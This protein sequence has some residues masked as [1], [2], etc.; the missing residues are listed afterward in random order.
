V[1]T[2][3]ALTAVAAPAALAQVAAPPTRSVTV[4]V[5]GSF[6]LAADTFAFTGNSV[7][8]TAIPV[9]LPHNPIVSPKA[10]APPNPVRVDLP[11]PVTEGGGASAIGERRR[12]ARA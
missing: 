2:V 4:P 1:L 12:A 3:A 11:P 6:T 10:I 9:T 7:V 8:T 5:S